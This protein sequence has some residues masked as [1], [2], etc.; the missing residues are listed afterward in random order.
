MPAFAFDRDWTVDV[1]PHPRHEAVPLSWVRH[2]A[3]ET[4]N[5]VYAIGNQQL[6]EEAAI[7]GVVDIVGRHPDDWETWLGGKQ[8]DGYYERFPLR[9]ERLALIADLHPEADEYIVVDDIDLSDV[10][11]WSHYHA[12]E[13]VPAVDRGEVDVA[14]PPDG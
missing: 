7:P 10:D 9:R 3:H 4:A 8:S 6:A 5:P 11:N 1:N 2:L 14:L 13:F 12:W